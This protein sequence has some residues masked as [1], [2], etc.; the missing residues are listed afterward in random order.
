M[1]KNVAKELRQGRKA[2]TKRIVLIV[3]NIGPP[4]ILKGSIDIFIHIDC[5]QFTIKVYTFI[6]SLSALD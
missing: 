5:E 3:N 1:V 2:N 4:I 6:G